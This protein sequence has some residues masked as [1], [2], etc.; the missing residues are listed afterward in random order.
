M[1]RQ[2]Q[3]LQREIELHMKKNANQLIYFSNQIQNLK[4]V[5]TKPVTRIQ[6]PCCKSQNIKVEEKISNKSSKCL[7]RNKFEMVNVNEH[8]YIQM[9][10]QIG[11]IN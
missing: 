7:K 2:K 8:Y 5:T 10:L 6:R 1:A 11:F 3:E 9:Y 4:G